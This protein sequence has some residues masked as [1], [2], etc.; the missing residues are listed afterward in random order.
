MRIFS[1]VI[2]GAPISCHHHH[3]Q[4]PMKPCQYYKQYCDNGDIFHLVY[5]P[6]SRLNQH[7]QRTNA[8]VDGP[9][10]FSIFFFITL[11]HKKIIIRCTWTT[12]MDGQPRWPGLHSCTLSRTDDHVVGVNSITR[13][14]ALCCCEHTCKSYKVVLELRCMILALAVFMHRL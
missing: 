8:T 12:L 7:T 14:L 10:S 1:V 2:F 4:A 13:R 9:R 3:R 6:E 5:W 11:W